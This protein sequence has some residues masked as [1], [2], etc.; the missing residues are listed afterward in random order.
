M[1]DP[2]PDIR[3]TTRSMKAPAGSS[4]TLVELGAGER[5]RTADLPL[6]RS[7]HA[8]DHPAAFLIR[9]GSLVV[10]LQLNEVISAK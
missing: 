6:T 8:G 3:S 9:A 1:V 4:N 2:L 5:I 7:F 10:W